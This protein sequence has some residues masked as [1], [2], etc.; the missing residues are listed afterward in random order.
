VSQSH[1][2]IGC[3]PT[4][5]KETTLQSSSI[6]QKFLPPICIS[7]IQW[8]A[9][10]QPHLSEN[11][12]RHHRLLNRVRLEAL[13]GF[14]SN[15]ISAGFQLFVRETPGSD[16]DEDEEYVALRVTELPRGSAGKHLTELHK[17]PIGKSPRYHPLKQHNVETR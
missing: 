10:P 13:V 8:L 3:L 1:P 14:F 15:E 12:T 4:T 16:R 6:R 7:G 11:N 5:K 17:G 9:D 2:R